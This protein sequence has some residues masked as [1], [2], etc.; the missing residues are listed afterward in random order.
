MR[1]LIASEVAAPRQHELNHAY[2]A[3]NAE[4]FLCA[5]PQPPPISNAVSIKLAHPDAIRS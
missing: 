1:S 2:D 5:C 4:R 3:C